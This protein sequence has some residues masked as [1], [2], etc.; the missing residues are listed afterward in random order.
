M[1]SLGLIGPSASTVKVVTCF[2]EAK[3]GAGRVIR[4]LATAGP[5]LDHAERAPFVFGAGCASTCHSGRH[6]SS[7]MVCRRC[8]TV[9][10]APALTS[11]K[12]R[13]SSPLISGRGAQPGAIQLEAWPK[14]AS[15]C[16]ALRR[17][18]TAPRSPRRMC[19]KALPARLYPGRPVRLL[20]C[21]FENG[22]FVILVGQ[23]LQSG[24]VCSTC[25]LDSGGSASVLEGA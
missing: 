16:T 11:T 18:C 17:M 10:Y 5:L 6:S 7:L 25:S 20:G 14:L 22:L 19:T 3:T 15:Y 4:I 12:R 13:T 9:P 23:T 24:R 1:K 21:V 2:C 8:R